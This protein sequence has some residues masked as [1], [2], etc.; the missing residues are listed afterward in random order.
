LAPRLADR[1]GELAAWDDIKLLSVAVNRL[2]RWWQPGLICIG[3][4]AHAMSPV[5]G[6]GVN[7]AIQD[8]VAAANLLAAPLRQKRLTDA[9]LAA[10]QARREWPMKVTQAMQVTVQN[11]L[12]SSILG[13]RGELA[14]PWPLKLFKHV[15][16]LRRI[17]ARLIGIGV[18]PE[19]IGPEL[20]PRP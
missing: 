6:V 7:L 13:S 20:A 8:A 15:P 14:T 19:H 16:W 4:A 5:G 1:V 3:D 2:E 18:R 9:D 11:R 17:P 10:V 12:I